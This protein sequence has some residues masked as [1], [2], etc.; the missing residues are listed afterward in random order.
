MFDV[1]TIFGKDR[2]NDIA[3]LPRNRAETSAVMFAF[4]TLALV[5]STEIRIEANGN[6]G[7]DEQSTTQIR[8]AALAHAIVGGF[9]LAGLSDSRVNTGIGDKLGRGFE[10]A[11][12]A[13][14]TEDDR[15]EHRP[16]AGD[17]GNGRVQFF[18]DGADFSFCVGD[19]LFNEAHL[20]QQG[21]KLE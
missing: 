14:L 8:R 20:L 15:A 10:A 7:G 2:V 5:E 13:D 1:R 6:V 3:E 18:H 19:L 21:A 11:N 16:N 12:I 17:G 4:G 9:K